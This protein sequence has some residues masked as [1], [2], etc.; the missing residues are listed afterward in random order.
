MS[1]IEYKGVVKSFGAKAVLDGLSLKIE[2]G[3]TMTIL[4]GSGSGKT[5]LL[6]ILLGLV[7][8]DGGQVLVDGRAV[9]EMDDEELRK[10]R[11]RIGM[12]FQG[13]AL[14]DSLNVK[15]NVAYPLRE[16][17]QY[18]EDRIAKIVADRLSLVG[19]PGTEMVMT[20]DLSG[21]MRKRVALARAIATDPEV[22]LYDEPTTGL[23]PSNT[24]RINN[25]IQD[26]QRQLKVTSVAVTHDMESAFAISDRLAL[27]HRGRIEFV[28]TPEEIRNSQNAV[29]TTFIQGELR[30]NAAP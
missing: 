9:S 20:N 3:E 4:G 17:F 21:G 29:V 13:G 8:P 22:L 26:L 12:L 30:S 19:L 6:K 2:K 24:R 14:F 27:L 25:L 10:T 1:F 15:E 7:Q 28:G 5:I 23:D 16:H 18:S 11:R